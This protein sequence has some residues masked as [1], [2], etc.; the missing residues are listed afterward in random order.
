LQAS[1]QSPLPQRLKRLK[2]RDIILLTAKT[3]LF[4]AL[5]AEKSMFRG[6]KMTLVFVFFR[7]LKIFCVATHCKA[8]LTSNPTPS[9]KIIPK[10]LW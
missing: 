1:P 3:G 6:R 5:L 9:K 4:Q 10:N 8:G 7:F 2:D